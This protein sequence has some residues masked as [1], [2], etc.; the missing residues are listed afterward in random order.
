MVHKRKPKMYTL[1]NGKEVNCRE[2]A[3]QLDI[4]EVAAR[5]R[6]KKSDDPKVIYRP[7]NKKTGGKK[8]V[9]DRHIGTKKNLEHEATEDEKLWKLVMKM[10]ANK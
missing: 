1:S 4:T 6:L 7:Y 3:E 8:R 2:V 10:G 9:V 5:Y